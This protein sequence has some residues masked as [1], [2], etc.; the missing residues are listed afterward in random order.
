ML[1]E[2]GVA[3]HVAPVAEGRS[4]GAILEPSLRDGLRNDT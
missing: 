3:I 4:N 2:A 1:E